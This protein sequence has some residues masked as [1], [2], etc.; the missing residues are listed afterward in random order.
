MAKSLPPKLPLETVVETTASAANVVNVAGVIVNRVES[1]R[2]ATTIRRAMRPR[3]ST[4]PHRLT[5]KRRSRRV[6]MKMRT[7]RRSSATKKIAATAAAAAAVVVVAVA[8][9]TAMA[10]Q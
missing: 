1:V 7:V 3:C 8:A 5:E 4:W 6:A 2:R 9:R 10:L